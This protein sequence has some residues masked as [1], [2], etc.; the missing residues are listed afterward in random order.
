MSVVI[1]I[2]LI[3]GMIC[4]QH[5]HSCLI[6]HITNIQNKANKINISRIKYNKKH[7]DLICLI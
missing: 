3:I 2:N 4:L 7:K 5:H 6:V 1:L